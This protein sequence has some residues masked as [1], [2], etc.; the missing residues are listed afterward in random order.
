MKLYKRNSDGSVQVWQVEVS[1]DSYRTIYGRDKGAKIISEWT[2]CE[3]KNVGR[4][5]STTGAEQAVLE[6][7][8]KYDKLIRNERYF[9]DKSRID[10]EVYVAPM[11]AKKYHDHKK[12]LTFPAWSDP[13]LDGGRGCFSFRGLQTRKGG[14][15]PSVPHIVERARELLKTY[16]NLVLDGELYNHDLRHELNEI[17]KIIRVT[18]PERLTPEF[19]KRSESMIQY[20]LYDGWGFE[21]ITKETPFFERRKALM[22]LLK[23]F[24]THFNVVWTRPVH[25]VEEIDEHY[26]ELVAK[27]FEGQIIRWGD[28]EYVNK[29]SDQ[30]L[31]RKDFE[32]DEFTVV[33]YEEGVGKASGKAFSAVCRLRKPAT[34]GSTTFKAGFA[35]FSEDDLVNIWENQ[36]EWLG[37]KAHVRFL[38]YSPYGKPLIPKVTAFR[39]DLK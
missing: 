6:A 14:D 20:W 27:E 15:I 3:P 26:E 33:G 10:D 24:S 17:M 36:K 31:K 19:L 18:K 7:K 35:G 34:D 39:H 28:C 5:N 22:S 13:K 30:L 25:S 32:D 1:G 21:G 16:P 9:P 4:K 2:K 8:A 37:K 11:L 29:R 23:G 12:K 38:K